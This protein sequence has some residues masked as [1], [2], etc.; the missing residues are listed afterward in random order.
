MSESWTRH[1]RELERS[2]EADAGDEA[3]ALLAE[4]YRRDG[5]VADAEAVARRGL[6]RVPSSA[7][8]LAVLVLALLDGGRE[9]EARVVLEERAAA[10]LAAWRPQAPPD[11]PA[12]TPEPELSVSAA[13]L[14]HAFET[15]EP[16][17]EAMITPDRLA[18]EAALRV[19][20]GSAEPAEA[21]GAFAESSEVLELGEAF[22]TRT[23]AELLEQQ[24]DSD[25]AARIRASLAATPAAERPS[26]ETATGPDPRVLAALE[27]WLENVRRLST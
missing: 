26:P 27:H 14:D 21:A 25:G 3:F 1:V 9:T 4:C 8:G 17:L 2:V 23:M 19:D 13:E 18:E 24:G 5:R 7:P 11:P 12:A 16:E 6:A 15:A 22:S 10:A 20:A